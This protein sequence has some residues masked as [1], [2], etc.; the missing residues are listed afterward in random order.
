MI[1]RKVKDKIGILIIKNKYKKT[2]HANIGE[3]LKSYRGGGHAEIGACRI[4]E[5]NKQK[6]INEI[7][8]ALT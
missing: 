8:K 2:K 7:I 1:V 4:S 6:T 3:I 5:K